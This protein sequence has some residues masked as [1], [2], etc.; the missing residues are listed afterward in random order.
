MQPPQVHT[1]NQMK[2]IMTL[3][4]QKT[5]MKIT[6]SNC[7]SSPLREVVDWVAKVNCSTAGMQTEYSSAS[8]V[9]ALAAQLGA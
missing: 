4:H 6:D 3:V 7:H 1:K 8:G 9:P 5:R 2:S